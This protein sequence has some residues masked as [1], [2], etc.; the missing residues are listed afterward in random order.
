MLGIEEEGG[1]EEWEGEVYTYMLNA[2]GASVARDKASGT[3]ILSESITFVTSLTD[4]RFPILS[5]T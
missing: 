3:H 1:G 2:V 4:S 5:V